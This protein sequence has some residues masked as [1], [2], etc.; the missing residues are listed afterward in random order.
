MTPEAPSENPAET[1]AIIAKLKAAIF[2]S[3]AATHI[4]EVR[5]EYDTD[6]DD[7]ALEA[8]PFSCT[9]ENGRAV[10]CPKLAIPWPLALEPNKPPAANTMLADA[11]FALVYL[12]LE[13]PPCLWTGEDGS[14]GAFRILVAS[15]TIELSH[16]RRYLNYETASRSF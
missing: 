8:H 11:I 2:D 15:R 1:A 7:E 13:H 3:L 9:D 5:V 12:L 4:A 14:F 16:T 6:G 10:A